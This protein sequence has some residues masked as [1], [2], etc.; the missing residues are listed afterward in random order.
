MFEGVNVSVPGWGG[1]IEPT[2]N[3]IMIALIIA[4]VFGAG[5]WIWFCGLD[6]TR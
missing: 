1:E 2:L 5:F 3:F 4:L 6:F